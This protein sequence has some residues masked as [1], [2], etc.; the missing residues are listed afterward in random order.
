MANN[1]TWTVKVDTNPEFCGVGAGN[2]HFA[3]GEAVITDARL[4][5]W[6]KAHKGYTVTENKPAAKNEPAQSTEDAPE[7]SAE[8]KP[9]DK[10]KPAKK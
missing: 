8:D 7:Q 5:A 3:H 10:P 9:A 2:A 1:K 4:A 6:F